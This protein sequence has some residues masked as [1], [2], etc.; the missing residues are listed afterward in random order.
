LNY[1]RFISCCIFNSW[2]VRSNLI[3]KIHELFIIFALLSLYFQTWISII[4][5]WNTN[6]FKFKK[7]KEKKIMKIN[8]TFESKT[9]NWIIISFCISFYISIEKSLDFD[10]HWLFVSIFVLYYGFCVFILEYLILVLISCFTLIYFK[11]EYLFFVCLFNF[12]WSFFE[13]Q[14]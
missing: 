8:I 4:I 14:N 3:L 2:S 5:F 6:Y 1:N 13:I 9:N 11:F 12:I 7:K 10:D